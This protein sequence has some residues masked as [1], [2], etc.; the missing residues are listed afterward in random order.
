MSGYLFFFSSLLSTFLLAVRVGQFVLPVAYLVVFC[1][2]LLLFLFSPLCLTAIELL[3]SWVEWCTLGTQVRTKKLRNGL[4][5]VPTAYFS[6]CV[7][8]FGVF[9]LEPLCPPFLCS[10]SISKSSGRLLHSNSF[11]YSIYRQCL[12]DFWSTT[13]NNNDN[14]DP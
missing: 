5:S 1:Q 14:S 2:L 12:D 11:Q 6:V 3:S 7:C 9:A 4:V 13:Q 8:S 10:L